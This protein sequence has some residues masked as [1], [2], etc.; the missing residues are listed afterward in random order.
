VLCDEWRA[1]LRRSKRSLKHSSGL[2]FAVASRIASIGVFTNSTA[3]WCGARR[4]ITPQGDLLIDE[5][6]GGKESYQREVA[7][8]GPEIVR[9]SLDTALFRS[10]G[11][12]RVGFSHQTY[13]EFLAAQ[14]LVD[15]G[16]GVQEILRLILHPD[17]SGKVVPQL[18]ETAGWL[19]ALIPELCKAILATDPAA[20]F[21]ADTPPAAEEHRRSAVCQILALFDSG[22][23][24]DLRIVAAAGKHL[25]GEW[26][27]YSGVADD[28]EPYI[29]DGSRSTL[30]R[31]AA[32]Q[33]AEITHQR[34]LQD[35]L[36]RLALDKEEP[37]NLRVAAAASVRTIGDE[38]TKAGLKPLVQ[39]TLASDPNDDLKG[40]A[41]SAVWPLHIGADELFAV[42]TPPQ[43][44]NYN[45]Q[46]QRFL[47]SDMAARIPNHTPDM[48]ITVRWARTEAAKPKMATRHLGRAALELLSAAVDYF[49]DPDVSLNVANALLEIAAARVPYL[50]LMSK[51][52]SNRDA[53]VALAAL[54]IPVC[55]DARTASALINYGLI[56]SDDVPSL[57]DAI[58]AQPP[59]DV[60]E[61]LAFLIARLLSGAPCRPELMERVLTTT[62]ANPIVSEALRPI[63][64]AIPLGSEQA[65]IL[66]ADFEDRVH[67]AAPTSSAEPPPDIGDLIAEIDNSRPTLFVDICYRRAGLSWHP[68]AEVLP[69]WDKLAPEVQARIVQ[70]AEYY[71]TGY[72]VA[73]T[74]WIETGI[75]CYDVTCGYWAMRLLV[76]VA[77]DGFNRLTGDVWHAWMPS[78]FGDSFMRE[79]PDQVHETIL[80][81]AYE[82]DPIR[83]REMVVKFIDGQNCRARDVLI[84][85]RVV[86][87]WDRA[88]AD[89]L[90]TKLVD[91]RMGPCTFRTILGTLMK[92]GDE[93]AGRIAA[94]VVREASPEAVQ[95]RIDAALG[96]LEHNP[97]Q[98][99]Q[100]VWPAANADQDFG[101][102]LIARLAQDPY[103]AATTRIVEGLHESQLAELQIW[104]SNNATDDSDRADSAQD[105]SLQESLI[106]GSDNLQWLSIVVMNNLIHRGTPEAPAAIRKIDA[107]KPDYRLKRVAHL[108]E[109]AV[110]QKTWKPLSPSQFLDLVIEQTAAQPR[111]RSAPGGPP[112]YPPSDQKIDQPLPDP[113][114]QPGERLF[115]KTGDMWQLQFEGISVSMKDRIGLAYIAN[116]VGSPDRSF[117]STELAQSVSLSNPASRKVGPEDQAHLP[118][119]GFSKQHLRDK[120]YLRTIKQELDDIDKALSKAAE[121]NDMGNAEQLRIQKQALIEGVQRITGHRGRSRMFS[122]EYEKAR[123]AVCA[124]I[125]RTTN[126]IRKC[127][128]ALATHLKQR[129]DRGYDCC[130][131]GDGIPWSVAVR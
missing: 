52:K 119:A 26:L 93:E 124:A 5:L 96:L 9:E 105:H 102:C 34:R 35:R 64:A 115:R 120:R 25:G 87:V 23:L 13:A 103:S 66:K 111:A 112:P 47:L 114:A 104:L 72:C 81:V 78:V 83:F 6:F 22:D 62:A 94:E 75:D 77:R 46:Y 53:R 86:P 36:L 45:G 56:D 79:P 51:I 30:A 40:N 14:Y 41:L 20:L 116:L 12:D 110:R 101:N 3:V 100:V 91:R 90:R 15:R 126:E 85:D 61:K 92:A 125:G 4:D 74:S 63:L 121:N 8:V 44:P 42:L 48:A 24:H 43:Q 55:P 117:F 10:V 69:E 108:A 54:A 29:T 7:D 84:L 109:D 21:A 80:K 82:R 97:S 98:G 130:Y 2:R 73:S 50:R 68:D 58:D 70:A 17:G 18:R 1:D 11:P 71:L 99:W 128:P 76:Q 131:N 89:L 28:L 49:H 38:H 57:L 107:R 16:V 95:K 32:V 33:I 65:E 60:Q 127:H 39:I 37:H 67:R 59:D 113:T 122:N 27:K 129:I 19:A 31:R 106:T 88:I 123:K 118:A